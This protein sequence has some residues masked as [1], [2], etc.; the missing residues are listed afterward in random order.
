MSIE[1]IIPNYKGSNLIRENLPRVLDS[2]A[3]SKNVIITIVDDG[4]G[5]EEE[6][7]IK[8]I[9]NDLIN[10]Y[11]FKINL[12]SNE[13][14]EGFS[15]AINKAAFKSNADILVFLNTDVSPSKNFLNPIIADFKKNNNLFGVG[16]MDKSEEGTKI[17]LRGRGLAKWRRGLLIHKRG[18]TKGNDTFWISGGSSAVNR[19]KFREMGGFDEIYNPFYW[20][21]IDLSYKAQKLGFDILFEN[22]SVVFHNHHEGA[23]KK[24]YDEDKINRIAYRNQFIFI[25]KNITDFDLFFSHLFWLPAHII[26]AVLRLDWQFVLGFLI[27]LVKIPDII[28]KRAR[29][30]KNFIVKDKNILAKFE[31]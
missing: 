26:K 5:K 16:L 11:S 27:A 23:I 12:L 14:N 8:S 17:I 29:Q 10:K 13:K 24:N 21:D 9:I 31:K 4:S 6:S 20:E 1:I 25:W 22:K 3:E 18:D 15:S 28:R 7:I 2:I 19:E 30:K